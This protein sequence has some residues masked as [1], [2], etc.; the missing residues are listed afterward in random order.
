MHGGGSDTSTRRESDPG[1]GQKTEEAA[2][3]LVQR[4]T[5][6]GLMAKVRAD[7][8]GFRT[9]AVSYCSHDIY[10]GEQHRSQQPQQ[11]RAGHPRTTN[12]VLE[13]K[14]AVQFVQQTYPTSKKS[15]VAYSRRK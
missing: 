4:L 7:A 9:L 13:V 10:G 6:G 5:G 1:N 11:G 15:D 8:A 3:S 2:T 14:A 12:G